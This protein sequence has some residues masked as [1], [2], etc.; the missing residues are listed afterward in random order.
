VAARE[1]HLHSMVVHSVIALAVVAAASCV[2]AASDATV[3]PIAPRTWPLLC[4]GSLVLLALAALPATL[5]G[6]AE[7]N[8]MYATWHA[9]HQAKLW[10][11]LLLLTMT[12]GELTAGLATGTPSAVAT[13]LALAIAVGNP[14]VCL[15]LSFY[16][17]RI[18]LG[19]QSVARTSYIP[20]MHREPAVDVLGEASRHVAEP[21]RVLEILEEAAP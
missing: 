5:T 2:I 13:P 8:R 10:L 6:I 20:D 3:G 18:T 19:R 15:L 12:A 9:S 11:S 21:A 1:L 14:A 16:G 4:W 17:L 7:R